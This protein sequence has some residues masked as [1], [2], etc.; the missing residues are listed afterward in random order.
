MDFDAKKLEEAAKQNI[1]YARW[2]REEKEAKNRGLEFKMY[3]EKRHQEDRDLWR[4]KDF[5][6]A[7]DKMSRAGYKGKHGDFHVPQD[8]YDELNSLYMQA[9]VGDY[10]GNTALKCSANWKKHIGK[11]QVE[12]IREFI[13]LTNITLTKYGWNPP[14]RWV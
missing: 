3:W 1:R 2:Q 12:V 4:L 7:V 13:K 11:T 9:T 10:D 14:E 8:S 6:N 5:A